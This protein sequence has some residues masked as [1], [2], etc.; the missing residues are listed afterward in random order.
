MYWQVEQKKKK[1]SDEIVDDLLL[2][3]SPAPVRVGV[4][5]RLYLSGMFSSSVKVEQIY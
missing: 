1:K 4:N 5:A 2:S 3:L